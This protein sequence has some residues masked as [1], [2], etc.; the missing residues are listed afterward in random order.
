MVVDG[1]GTRLW[2]YWDPLKV[3]C[4]RPSKSAWVR[5]HTCEVLIER[6]ALKLVPTLSD[7]YGEPFGDP[8]ALPTRLM[9]WELRL[10]GPVHAAP[11]PDDARP[12]GE[13][14]AARL[15]LQHGG[16]PLAQRGR[17]R[18]HAERPA[19]GVQLGDVGD[20]VADVAGTFGRVTHLDGAEQLA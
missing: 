1:K 5:K 17:R 13:P 14:A 12:V 10:A 7:L 3:A 6:D 19:P 11:R 15:D 18:P 9:E 20:R 4:E 2:R 16:Q 8:S